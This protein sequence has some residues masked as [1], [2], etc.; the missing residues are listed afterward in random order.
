MADFLLT[1]DTSAPLVDWQHATGTMAGEVLRIPYLSNETLASAVL[2]LPDARQLPMTVG[3]LMVSVLLPADTPDGP[4]DV[5]VVDDVGNQRTYAG[6]VTIANAGFLLTLDT[7]APTV[8]WGT[9]HN[10]TAGEL[11][12]IN[13]VAS[14]PLATAVLILADSRELSMTIGSG[15]L[16]VLLPPDAPNGLASIRV[17][18]DVGN[19]RLYPGLVPVTGTVVV[20]TPEPVTTTGG[21]PTPTRA[22]RRLSTKYVSS[23]PVAIPLRITTAVG[24]EVGVSSSAASSTSASTSGAFHEVVVPLRLSSSASVASSLTTRST[25]ASGRSDGTLS[26]RD[27]KLLEELLLLS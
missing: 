19:E 25:A 9:P 12:G 11:M 6:I 17:G 18:D 20:V 22:R 16:S 27:G 10:T 13:Y 8:T 1:L 2:T 26:R 5:L 23:K 15:A 3:A 21:L 7:T 14:E 4:A 24:A